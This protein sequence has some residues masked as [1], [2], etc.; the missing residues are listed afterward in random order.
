MLQGTKTPVIQ[1]SAYKKDPKSIYQGPSI[2]KKNDDFFFVYFGTHNNKIHTIFFIFSMFCFAFISK[3]QQQKNCHF[4]YDLS[5]LW[6][7]IYTA[8]KTLL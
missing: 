5:M 6:L 4:I 7:G 3:Q 2:T 1:N 8:N